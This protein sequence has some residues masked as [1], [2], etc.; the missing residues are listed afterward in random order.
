MDEFSSVREELM[1]LF[2]D[3]RGLAQKEMELARAEMSEQVS[4]ARMTAMF[5]TIAA[6]FGLITL[7]FVAVTAMFLLDEV[8]PLWAAALITTGG[9]LLL[10]LLFA[11]V[12]Y[13]QM[14]QLTFAPK[15][16]MDSVNED[17]RWARD[18]MNFS[19]K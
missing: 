19:A 16:T 8:M 4:Y 12:A 9:L 10:T 18:R 7:A 6:V 1:D 3:V 11:G 17:V 15:K 2:Q 14:T 13:S 5:G